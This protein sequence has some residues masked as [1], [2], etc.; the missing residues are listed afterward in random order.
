MRLLP[1]AQQP[2]QCN[3][4]KTEDC[5]GRQT[6]HGAS[7]TYMAY[8]IA[9]KRGDADNR[10][11][12][13][14]HAHYD[15]Y[16]FHEMCSILLCVSPCGARSERFRSVATYTKHPLS[17]CFRQFGT[18]YCVQ[19]SPRTASRPGYRQMARFDLHADNGDCLGAP[20]PCHARLLA[21]VPKACKPSNQ[22]SARDRE[23]CAINTVR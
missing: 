22:R 21:T 16:D 3:S 1:P 14:Q 23:H 12:Y 10:A 8:F 19:Y 13:A 7:L 15:S 2:D 20:I 17:R 6:L 4:R 5:C 18:V 11:H 9:N